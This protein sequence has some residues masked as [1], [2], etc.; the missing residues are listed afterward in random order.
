MAHFQVDADAVMSST[1]T[2]N[3]TIATIRSEVSRLCGQLSALEGQWTGQAS[4]AFHALLAEW[5]TTQG[6]V[7]QS[8]ESISMALGRAGERYADIEQANAAMF[9]V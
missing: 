1:A 4:S 5:R 2:M 7:E 3:G 9:R 6:A 8:L